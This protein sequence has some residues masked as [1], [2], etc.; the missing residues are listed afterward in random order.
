MS[1]RAT[2]SG[3][4]LVLHVRP[5]AATTGLSG[6]HGD[7]LAVRLAAP[8]VDGKANEALVEYIAAV[9]GVPRRAVTII[10]GASARRKIV[11]VAGV[12]VR[13]ATRLLGA[14]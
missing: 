10:S 14:A 1:V 9:L 11:D 4:R 6:R 12:D 8:P 7:A 3:V 2:A 13:N 5:G